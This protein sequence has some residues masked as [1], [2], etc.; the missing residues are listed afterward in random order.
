MTNSSASRTRRPARTVSRPHD[1]AERQAHQAAD[2]VARGGTVGSWSFGSVALD[3]GVHR[4]GP[5]STPKQDEDKRLAEIDQAAK[6]ANATDGE[7]AVKGAKKAAEG[8]AAMPVGKQAIQLVRDRPDVASVEKFLGTT[9]G[10]I[11]IGGV[12][13]AGLTG[14][15]IAKQ[16]MPFS[17]PAIPISPTLSLKPEISGP[18]NAP[19]G[20]MITL[21]Y[22][23]TG[24]AAAK[25]PNSKEAIAA[26]IAKIKKDN[27]WL[28]DAVQR[29]RE[30]EG[31][32]AGGAGTGGAVQR[33]PA[34]A[35]ESIDSAPSAAGVDD[36]VA[37]GGRPLDPALRHS[38]E[39]RFRADFSGVRLH[40]GARASDAAAQLDA[41]AFTVGEDIAF[42]GSIPD[43]TTYEGR[44]LLAHELA[45][46]VQ[47][48]SAPRGGGFTARV[49]RRSA[50]EWLGI[51]FGTTEGAW[52][53]QE[54]RSYLD[55]LTATGK[56]DGAFD[57]D[58]K[59]RAIVRKWKAASPGWEL[60]GRQK[61][62]L[63]DEMLDGPT[64]S[65]DEDAILDVLELSDAGDLR[66]IFASPKRRWERLDSDLDG[67][68]HDRLLTFVKTRINGGRQ[69]L[70]DGKTDI[71]DVVILGG[72]VPKGAPAFAFDA[73]RLE[74]RLSEGDTADEIVT[75][76]EALSPADRQKAA[77]HLL[78]VSLVSAMD[79]RGRAAMSYV[80][81]TGDRKEELRVQLLALNA[82]LGKLKRIL[83]RLFL[84]EIPAKAETLAAQ[85]KKLTPAQ[86]KAAKEILAPKQYDPLDQD[87]IE[88]Y[89]SGDDPDE[90]APKSTAGKGADEAPAPTTAPTTAA[91]RKA[92]AAREKAEKERKAKEEEEKHGVKSEYRQ[93]VQEAL[94]KLIAENYQSVVLDKGTH[95]DQSLIEPMAQPAKDA[96]DAV[97]GAFYSAGKHPALST[98]AA[99]GKKS[100][101][102]SWHARF[103]GR[104]GGMKDPQRVEAAV[105]WALY[106]LRENMAIRLVNDKYDATPKF[107]GGGVGVNV[108]A[109]TQV[110]IARE[111]VKDG[112]TADP[113][114]HPKTTADKLLATKRDWAGMSSG[115]KVYVDLYLPA[116][117]DGARR[118]RWQMLQTLIHEYIHT[119][120]A[121]P[122][123]DY[124][125][126]TF[127][128]DSTEYT[129]LIE[130][131]D[132]VFTLMVWARLAPNTKDPELRTKVE[133]ATD[134]ALPP[135]DVPPPVTY[136]AYAEAIRLVEL[137]GI[138]NV[139][140]AYFSGLVDRIRGDETKGA[141]R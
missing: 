137:V 126:D 50:G 92:A 48:R 6:D 93:K 109:K 52:T 110:L 4:D 17:V 19:T 40:D 75:I 56:I 86:A 85:T 8:L 59:A 128:S 62:L 14:L 7:K 120:V 37:S 97:F 115:G 9:A 122:Y 79:E 121:G 96:T 81:S 114:D 39:S 31:G 24:G 87:Q 82:K 34:T 29:A 116:D 32:G 36:A 11:A 95:A 141:R 133:G 5:D 25:D 66:T 28:T 41:T 53:D 139:M 69:T 140:A 51:F 21:S 67:S 61:G 91:G 71:A 99:A 103:T 20:V 107:A 38:M 136:D 124:A 98:K 125:S 43:A 106:Y 104:V 112:V 73:A 113:L 76:V 65:E 15:A 68:Q 47:Q 57:A 111:L 84:T 45:H 30:A 105:T 89:P 131:V 88:I 22:K 26:D 94:V 12:A 134:A 63:L 78:H 16:P 33:E 100:G 64:G 117:R 129:T 130:G 102:P 135:L 58:N 35:T 108:A 101:L 72:V 83:P 23:G 74:A 127:G 55:T 54:L 10:K 60:T 13:V 18:L 77:D 49:H 80:D 3:A 27:A 123:S 1:P 90:V 44:H 119:L 46:V 42:A 138:R 132:E 118:A 70:E 2:L